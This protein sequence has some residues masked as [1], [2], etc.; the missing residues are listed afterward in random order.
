MEVSQETKIAVVGRVE[1]KSSELQSESDKQ[2][3]REFAGFI[4]SVTLSHEEMAAFLATPEL[5]VPRVKR[6]F[7]R[8]RKS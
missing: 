5:S 2:A 6:L 8:K 4:D 1:S 3:D 7:R